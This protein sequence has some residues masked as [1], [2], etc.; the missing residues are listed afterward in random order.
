MIKKTTLL[1]TT[2]VNKRKLY[3]KAK[4]SLETTN[5]K[6]CRQLI[7]I[8]IKECGIMDNNYP[9][10]QNVNKEIR[11]ELCNKC[12]HYIDILQICRYNKDEE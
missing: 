9:R 10:C 4:L 5:T 2:V 6:E 11:H 3:T 12:Q 7:Y 1:M 8:T